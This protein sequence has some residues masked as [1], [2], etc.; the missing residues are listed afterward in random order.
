VELAKTVNDFDSLLVQVIDETVKYCLGDVNASIICNYLKE[1]N[2]PMSEIP[3]KPELFSE[4][5][6]QILGFGSRQI[7]CAASILEETILEVLC[8]KLGVKLDCEKPVN[9]PRQVRKLRE[10][11][12]NEGNRR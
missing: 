9:F 12:I 5:L 3:N 10:T 8:K 6:R 11:Y 2:L 1:R 7:L 4:E